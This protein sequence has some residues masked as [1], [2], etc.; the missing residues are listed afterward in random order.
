[1]EQ[2]EQKKTPAQDEAK[3]IAVLSYITLIG[4]I[5]AFV[6]N[7]ERKLEF[8]QYHI[9]QSLGLI[10]TAVALAAVGTIPV[11]GWIVSTLGSLVLIYL[12]VVGLLN[13][14]NGKKVPLPMVGAKFEE[15]FSKL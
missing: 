7:Q 13:A 14:I 10:L 2:T 3:N 8:A 6:M 9:G 4:L 12:W 1:M 11:L 15:W 5:V